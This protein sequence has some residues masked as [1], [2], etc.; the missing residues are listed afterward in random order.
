MEDIMRPE[1]KQ[2]NNQTKPNKQNLKKS[3][4]P[5]PRKTSHHLPSLQ[6]NKPQN[7]PKPMS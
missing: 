4:Q 1:D 7:Y 6:K 3:K 2:T 5:K